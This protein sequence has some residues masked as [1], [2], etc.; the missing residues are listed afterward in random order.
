M[1]LFLRLLLAHFIGDFPF[2]AD[3]IYREKMHGIQGQ[4][5]HGLIIGLLCAIFSWPV[6]FHPEVWGL[7]LV[8]IAAHIFVDWLKMKIGNKKVPV[9]WAF[10]TDQLLHIS[11]LAL[12]F[13]FDFSRNVP[14]IQHPLFALYNSNKLVVLVITYIIAT[15][16][17]TYFLDAFKKSYFPL[18]VE[19]TGPK[20]INYGLVERGL[21][22]AVFCSF[23]IQFYPL[24]LILF[25]ADIM[26]R[27]QKGAFDFLLNL[28][29]AGSGGLIIKAV[30][31]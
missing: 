24:V 7:I 16:A 29:Y 8:F 22:M 18:L 26:V 27:R 19:T 4:V 15:F 3:Q 28:I 17:G 5:L 25:L 21:I 23:S 30:F 2:Q 13:L 12:V 11:V 6:L 10:L 31:A 20:S 14:D 1:F 9:F